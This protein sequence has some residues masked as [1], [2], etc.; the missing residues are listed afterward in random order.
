MGRAAMR[1]EAYREFAP[2]IDAATQQPLQ[3]TSEA[4]SENEADYWLVRAEE[5]V[6]RASEATHPAA[7]AAHLKMASLCQDRALTAR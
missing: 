7:R 5:E 6:A 2:L 3:T 1:Q 4:I